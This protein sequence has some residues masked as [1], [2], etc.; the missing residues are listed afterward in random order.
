MWAIAV[1]SLDV[2][3]STLRLLAHVLLADFL[4]A[5]VHLYTGDPATVRVDQSFAT[6]LF[7]KGL[8]QLRLGS[9]ATQACSS[10]VREL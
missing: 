8:G 6:W 2:A 4:R 9:L 3:M 1:P 10:S 7:S 5:Q